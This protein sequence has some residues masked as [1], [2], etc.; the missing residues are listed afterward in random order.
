MSTLSPSFE[1]FLPSWVARQ[2][3]YRGKTTGSP[4]L[5]RIGS[6]R[7][8]DPLGEVGLEDH[9]VLDE[10]GAEPVAAEGYAAALLLDGDA[11]LERES[12]R[13]AEETVRRWFGAAGLV[14]GAADGGVVVVTAGESAAVAA[15][16][17]WD[18]AGFAEREYALRR[19]LSLPPAVRV[20]A[21]VSTPEGDAPP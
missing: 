15:L 6:I 10:S 21:A 4:R 9:L 14:R 20:P 11:M 2:R 8:E 16:V 7:W 18:A 5:R 12:L 13:A 19:E 3:W 17:R 1:E